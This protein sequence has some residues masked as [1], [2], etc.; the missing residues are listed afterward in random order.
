MGCNMIS[1]CSSLFEIDL[2]TA[3]K[4]FWK[5][6]A[7]NAKKDKQIPGS[8]SAKLQKEIAKNTELEAKEKYP[9]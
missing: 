8:V 4:E 7:E 2:E 6:Q 1:I 5:K 9:K 3:K